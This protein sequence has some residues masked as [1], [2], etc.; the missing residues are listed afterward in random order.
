MQPTKHEYTEFNDALVYIKLLSDEFAK[1]QLSYPSE[2][3]SRPIL[4]LHM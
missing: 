4:L 1:K 3:Y 2:R